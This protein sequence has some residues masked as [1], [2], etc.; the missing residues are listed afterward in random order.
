MTDIIIAGGA[1]VKGSSLST[2]LHTV[3]AAISAANDYFYL[4]VGALGG[5]GSAVEYTGGQFVLRF[6]GMPSF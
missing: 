6:Y 2:T 4:T 5:G 3:P 1:W